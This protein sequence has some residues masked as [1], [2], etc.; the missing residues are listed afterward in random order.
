MIPG[1]Y[2]GWTGFQNLGDEAMFELCRRRFA[3]VHWS[4]YS[5][6]SNVPEP[7]AFARRVVTNPTHLFR[8]LADECRSGRRLRTLGTRVASHVLGSGEREVAML[9]GGTLING[10][11]L[12]PYVAMRKRTSS[13]VP[14]FGSGVQNPAFWSGVPG[15]VDSRRLW[16]AELND[17]PVVGVRGPLSKGLLDE[18][19]VRNVIV[20]GDPAV[21]F[22]SAL[23]EQATNDKQ[24][25]LRIAINCGTTRYCSGNLQKVHDE[26]AS[27]ASRLV[28]SGAFVE[29]LP[30]WPEDMHSCYEVAKRAELNRSAIQPT[31]SSASAYLS[32]VRS[33]DLLIA[34]KL[35]AAILAAAANVPFVLFEY[36]PKC[37]DFCRSIEW[38]EF[39]IPTSRFEAGELLDLMGGMLP[40]LPKLQS[41]LCAKMCALVRRFEEYCL[42]IETILLRN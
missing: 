19:G 24:R 38:E 14:V 42:Q 7:V 16:A 8:M 3:Q 9:G 32:K 5:M 13:L 31:L 11:C 1:I 39:S 2:I 37:L 10:E 35:H 25:P 22:H 29:L 34:L 36:Q 12:E 15:W 21:L 17:L 41:R 40:V 23:A 33:F 18:V 6:V 20:S 26:M 27:V 30:V 4:P 28:R